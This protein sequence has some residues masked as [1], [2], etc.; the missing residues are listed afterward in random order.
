[1]TTIHRD[2]QEFLNA[3]RSENTKFLLI[4]AHALAFHVEARL[5][6]DLDVFVEPTAEN[7]AR[8]LRAL[9]KFGSSSSRSGGRRSSRTSGRPV[10]RKTWSTSRSSK[11]P[12][13]RGRSD[14]APS[15]AS[16][17]FVG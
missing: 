11:S 2:W 16:A 7:G 3:L 4:G 6:E 9:E 8:I 1:M 13:D 15:G 14:S 17:M 5:T 12:G 10:E